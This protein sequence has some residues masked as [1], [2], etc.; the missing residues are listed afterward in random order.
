MRFRKKNSNCIFAADAQTGNII[1]LVFEDMF[2]ARI[3]LSHDAP[4][5]PDCNELFCLQ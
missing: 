4:A 3:G 1:W 5:V 2:K